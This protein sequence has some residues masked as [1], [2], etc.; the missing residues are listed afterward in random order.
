MK[1]DEDSHLQNKCY[2]LLHICL[3]QHC[4]GWWYHHDKNHQ[5]SHC[6]LRE[7]FLAD[8]LPRIFISHVSLDR[9]DI[10]EMFGSTWKQKYCKFA[11][12][13]L[14]FLIF[15]WL[16]VVS[17]Y[18]WHSAHVRALIGI[19]SLISTFNFK[20]LFKLVKEELS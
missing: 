1:W 7:C 19:S 6:S 2:T 9:G 16:V 4:V 8:I 14:N 5:P 12:K 11:E 18:S 17:S 13:E 3:C 15:N 10:E 20:V